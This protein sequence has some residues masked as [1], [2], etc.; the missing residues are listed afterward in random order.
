MLNGLNAKSVLAAKTID[1]T[2]TIPKGTQIDCALTTRVVTEISGFANCIVT[3]H[4]YSANGRTLLIEKMSEVEGE[5]ASNSMQAGQRSLH[6]LWT[7]LR[8]PGGVTIELASPASDGLGGA[9]LAGHVD[10][11]WAERIGGAYML[12]L[13]KDLITYKTAVD[14]PAGGSSYLNNTTQQTNSIA[15][16]VLASTINIRPVLFANQ[17][18][19]VAIYVARDLDFSKIYVVRARQQ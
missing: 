3:D 14:A 10:N 2:L 9:G 17:G 15:E 7:R 13:V 8:K 16:K 11:R 19:R 18:A 1:E 4:V 5:Y 6:I 12:S